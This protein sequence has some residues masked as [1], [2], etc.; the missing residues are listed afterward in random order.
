MRLRL[1]AD[2]LAL[3]ALAVTAAPADAPSRAPRSASHAFSSCQ[4]ARRLRGAPSC[5]RRP[6]RQRRAR[7]PDARATRPRRQ[8]AAPGARRGRRRRRRGHLADQRAGGGR[9]RAGHG[10]D[11]RPDDLRARQRHAARGRRARAATPR[12]LGTLAL[13][14]GWD[15][16]DAAAQG[17]R[18]AARQRPARRAH[19]RGRRLRPARPLVLRTQDV[20]GYDRRRPPDRP[21]RPRRR[22]L[23]PRGASHGP[24]ERPRRPR[25]GCRAHAHE[26]PRDRPASTRRPSRCRARPAPGGLLRRRRAHRLHRRPRRRAC[27]PSTPTR[28]SPAARPSTPRRR[29]STSRPSAGRPRADDAPSDRRR[30]TAS[31]SREPDRTT[32]AASGMVA[33]H[34]AQPVLALGAQGR[35]ARRDDGRRGRRREAESKR[36]DARSATASSSSAARSAGSASG[37]RIYAVRFIGDVGYVVTFRQ[38]DPLYTVDLSDPAS[39]RVARRAEDP[40]LLGLPAPGRRRPAARHRPGRDRRRAASRGSSSRCST[41]P[42]SRSR[43][44][45]RRRGSASAGRARRPSGT[46]TRS[47]GGRR[48]SSRCCRS[49][50]RAFIGAAGFRV[51]RARAASRRSGGSATRHGASWTPPIEP[52]GR[53]RRPAVHGLEPRRQ[54]ERARRASRARLGRRSRSRRRSARRQARSR[55]RRSVGRL[56]PLPQHPEDAAR[57]LALQRLALARARKSPIAS[58]AV[59]R[60]PAPSRLRSACAGPG[61]APSARGSS[62]SRRLARAARRASRARSARRSASPYFA[63]SGDAFAAPSTSSAGSM[64][65][66]GATHPRVH[67]RRRHALLRQQRDRRLADAH[68]GQQRLD[69]V[70]LRRG[71]GRDGRAQLLRVGGRERAQRVLDAQ[72]ELARGPPRRGRS[73]AG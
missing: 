36:H 55:C 27:R 10:Q 56:E 33:R 30:S 23:L 70:E 50:A 40:R 17:P 8:A 19:D 5:R 71:I 21:Q 20:D 37:E 68:R 28:S 57:D 12:L 34:A 35:P 73:A 6:P 26:P 59:P 61:R 62:G 58:G 14:E 60:A 11:R 53:R 46:T 67:D 47:C 29:A 18:A 44:G 43:R 49:T 69:V 51:E 54:G 4:A 38:T 1:L 66:A 7:L 64:R 72:A 39:P 65:E 63:H 16:T 42:T 3:L 25:A 15:A 22:L 24:A 2:S 41:S 48:R 45:S 32:Y 31:T 9:R 13:D 52:R